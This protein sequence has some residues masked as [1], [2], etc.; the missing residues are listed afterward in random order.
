MPLV[1]LRVPGYLSSSGSVVQAFL[2]A[3]TETGIHTHRHNKMNS[4][5]QKDRKTVPFMRNWVLSLQHVIDTGKLPQSF[6][7]C[8][9]VSPDG[10]VESEARA[11]HVGLVDDDYVVMGFV[12]NC[13][14]PI[15]T[16]C[17]TRYSKSCLKYLTRKI[18]VMD[19]VTFTA[20]T[21]NY[22]D[23][24]CPSIMCKTFIA[25]VQ[26]GSGVYMVSV[27]HCSFC[28]E[29]PA[30]PQENRFEISVYHELSEGIKF[31]SNVGELD[32]EWNVSARGSE[33]V[34]VPQ[35]DLM[36]RLALAWQAGR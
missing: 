14:N 30:D 34:R 12:V 9:W 32:S 13:P 24:A 17:P 18:G 10:R 20:Q 22:S 25:V 21:S 11:H 16:P 27:E 33:T 2:R 1:Y 28:F 29:T 15:N 36:D 23:Y 8:G 31:V 6:M 4:V 7:P 5:Y 19:S 3:Q 35:S 26:S